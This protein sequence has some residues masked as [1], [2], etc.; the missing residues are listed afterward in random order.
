MRAGPSTPAATAWSRA[1]AP[2]ARILGEVLSYAFSSDGGHISIPSGDGLARAMRG[3]L[4]QGRTA[5]GEVDYVCAHATSTPAG[6]AA[7]AESIAAVFGPVTP[8][9]SST[10]G[11]TGHELWMSGASQVVYS[12]LMAGGGFIAP[13]LNFEEPDESSRKISVA[14]KTLE[15]PLRRVLCNAAGF[16]GTNSCLLLGFET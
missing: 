3:A 9:V 4:Q 1:A 5:P 16:G 2:R 14:A 13:N 15:R 8:P 7:E 10:K 11:M 12:T 6:D